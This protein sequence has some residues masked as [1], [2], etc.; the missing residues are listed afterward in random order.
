MFEVEIGNVCFIL[1]FRFIVLRC[2]RFGNRLLIL[3]YCLKKGLF[4]LFGDLLKFNKFFIGYFV[5]FD[6]LVFNLL[7]SLRV[8]NLLFL[9]LI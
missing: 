8:M 7:R 9:V 1:N 5:V 4:I 2:G 3:R 6:G